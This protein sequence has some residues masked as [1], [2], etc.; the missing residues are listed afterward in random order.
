MHDAIMYTPVLNLIRVKRHQ[1]NTYNLKTA[2]TLILSNASY[3]ALRT[4]LPPY[5]WPIYPEGHRRH[6]VVMGLNVAV[7]PD[8]EGSFVSVGRVEMPE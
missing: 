6:V 3:N 1:F 4:Q 8:F 5:F 7:L 2:N